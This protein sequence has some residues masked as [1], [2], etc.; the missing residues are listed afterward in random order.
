VFFVFLFFVLVLR[1]AIRQHNICATWHE[2]TP[3]INWLAIGRC[4]DHFS[5]LEAT[6]LI[7]Q[8]ILSLWVFRGDIEAGFNDCRSGSLD[9]RSVCNDIGKSN[10]ISQTNR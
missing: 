3:N 2:L 9:R 5:R 4:A 8:S 1:S 7:A 10:N 6:E